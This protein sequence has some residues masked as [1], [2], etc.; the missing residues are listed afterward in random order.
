M[1]TDQL[2]YFLAVARCQSF[3]EAAKEVY[4]TQPAITHQIAAL[5][6]ELGTPLFK[7]TT[8]SVSLTE[9]GKLFTD[10]ARQI[11]S[12]QENAQ[13]NLQM[14]R[15]S[16]SKR[17]RIGYLCAPC[18]HFLPQ[19]LTDFR[20]QYPQVELAL[21]R[22]HATGLLNMA[23]Q[24]PFDFLFSVYY[25]LKRLQGYTC[26][27]LTTDYYCLVCAKDSP[28]LDGNTIDYEKLSDE[29]FLFLSRDSG[30]YMY[31]QGLQI[32]RELGITP[33]SIREYPQIDDVLFAV[34]CKVGV[35]IMPRYV[36]EYLGGDLVFVPIS[37]SG[38]NIDFGVA[39][40]ENYENPAVK[41]LLDLLNYYL[42]EHPEV[43]KRNAASPPCAGPDWTGLTP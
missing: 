40:R 31:K 23:E 32:L 9:A 24:Q 11:L 10:Y 13:R 8:R 37:S 38:L 28:Y 17:L 16:G 21:V 43:F 19:I 15:E 26:Q 33:S 12:Q 30:A 2:R 34:Q 29:T 35:S 42:A 27:K 1:N 36:R 22:D 14:L 7:R 5:E 18:L 20:N 3:T 4:I 6:K 25:D 41:W 39:W